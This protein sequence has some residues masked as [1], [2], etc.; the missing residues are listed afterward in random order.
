MTKEQRQRIEFE[1]IWKGVS[2]HI[3]QTKRKNI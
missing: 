3:Q 1:M 2:K